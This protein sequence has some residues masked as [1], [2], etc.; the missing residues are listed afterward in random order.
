MG[1]ALGVG[2]PIA[3]VTGA[4]T[5]VTGFAPPDKLPC[6]NASASGTI[7]PIV[8]TRLVLLVAGAVVEVVVLVVVVLLGILVSST[9]PAST[10]QLRPANLWPDVRGC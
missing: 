6:S 7:G 5:G 2:P 3:N 1:A 8:R 4:A 10:A 9:T